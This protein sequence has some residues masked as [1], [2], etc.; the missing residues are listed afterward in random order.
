MSLASRWF[1]L[2]L[3]WFDLPSFVFFFSPFLCLS[4][5]RLL[6]LLSA[7]ADLDLRRLSLDL[8]LFLGATTFSLDLLLLAFLLTGDGLEAL[9]AAQAFRSAGREPRFP[10]LEDSF[11][12]DF[13]AV[14]WEIIIKSY[15]YR[16]VVTVLLTFLPSRSFT[17]S[18][19]PGLPPLPPPT[20]PSRSLIDFLTGLNNG[21]IVVLLEL[22][23][24]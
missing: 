17:A 10:S 22:N 23:R 24:H 1:F 3:F 15:P 6:F 11:S 5:D 19:C 8:L 9:R 20:G 4:D 14:S 12:F 21:W 2:L 13:L 18:R 16:E 7:S